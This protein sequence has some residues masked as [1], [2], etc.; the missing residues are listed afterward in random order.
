[1]RPPRITFVGGLYHVSTRCNNREFYFQEDYDFELFLD[2]LGKA[3]EEYGALIYAYC[4]TS[5]HFHMI[6]Q[7][8]DEDNLSDFMREVNGNFAQ[9]YN[10]KHRKCGRFWQQRFHSTII[11]S[12]TQLLNTLFYIDLQMVRCGVVD[13]PKDWKWG[14]YQSYAYGEINPLVD[15]HPLYLEFADSAEKRQYAYRSMIAERIQEKGLGL[16]QNPLV[17][18]GIVI[19]SFGFVKRVISEYAKHAYYQGRD[20]FRLQDVYTAYRIGDPVDS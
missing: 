10:R 16:Q 9:A 19:G 7:T 15:L 6:I 2:N 13:D 1:M 17:S 12:E 14:S 18:K 3:K 5:N 8:P 20:L 4:L 11:D